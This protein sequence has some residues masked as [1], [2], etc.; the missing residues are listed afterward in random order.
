MIGAKSIEPTL[1]HDLSRRSH[2][3]EWLDSPNIDPRELEAALRDLARF[4]GTM[5]GHTPILRWL[6]AVIGNTPPE[7]PL[8]VL[9]VGCG[10]GD[11]LRAIRRWSRRRGVPLALHGLDLNPETIRIARAA[12]GAE[13]EITYHAADAFAYRPDD[14]VDLIV[15][16]LLAHHLMDIAIVG[17]LRWMEATARRGWL[18]C[19][20]QRHLV[21]Y[22]FIGLTGKLSRLHPMVI[23][24]GRISVARSL[25]RPEWKA[26]I[27]TA[28]IPGDSVTIR[29]F[30][31]RYAIGRVR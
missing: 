18:I 10:Y 16:S 2:E 8:S 13:D 9:D 11:L 17:F 26:L 22:Y 29:W 19:D 1:R 24:D 12:T 4:N 14:P 7:R 27:R 5:F 15:S 21:P 3:A 6:H 23:H 31:F 25:T 28:G 30:L 20:L